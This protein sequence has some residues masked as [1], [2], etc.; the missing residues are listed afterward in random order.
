VILALFSGD[1]DIAQA[2]LA[3]TLE[4]PDR[5][6][7][8]AAMLI[9]A[10]VA[11]NSGDQEHMR[12][13][14]ELAMLQFR[15]IGDAWALGMTLSSLS[16]CLMIAGDLDGAETVLDEATELLDTLASQDTASLLWLR[17]AEVNIRRGDLDAAREHVEHVVEEADLRREEAVIVRATLA[18]IELLAGNVDRARE[19]VDGLRERVGGLPNVR[20]EQEHARAFTQAMIARLA[21]E[22]DDFETAAEVTDK[23]IELAVATTDMPIVAIVGT[24]SVE[25]SL[26]RGNV[27]AAAEQLGACVVLRGA[28]DRS[29]PELAPLYAAIAGH[30]AAYERGRGLSRDAAIA[31]LASDALVVGAQGERDEDRDD[32]AHPADGPEDV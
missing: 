31:R 17:L 13:D 28:E 22:D 29:N 6:T 5:W 8:A 32:R 23:A 19:I 21:L 24:G 7:R 12:A 20:P 15:E 27:E 11:E 26:R 30:E 3:E 10:H 16:S 2:R 4:H 25:L 18:R 1:D 14:L 9:R